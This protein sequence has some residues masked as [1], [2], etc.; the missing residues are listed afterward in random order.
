MFV[1]RCYLLWDAIGADNDGRFSGALDFGMASGRLLCW[2]ELVDKIC[3]P[4]KYP[5]KI[6]KKPTA[7]IRLSS[8]NII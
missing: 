1:K 4:T 2:D 6:A 3:F 5:Y 7:I 8:P